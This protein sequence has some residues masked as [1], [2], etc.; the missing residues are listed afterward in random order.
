M[1]GQPLNLTKIDSKVT[2]KHILL[3]EDEPD[4][5]LVTK[6]RLEL[7]GF[8]VSLA[9]DGME[10][11]AM[12]KQLRPDLVLLD[13]KMPQLDGYQVCKQLK[14]YEATKNIPVILFSGSSS[15]LLALERKCLELGADDFIRKPFETKALIKK[16]ISL[17]K[18][19]A[20]ENESS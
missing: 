5:A 6:T 12:V 11:L 20:G 17:T 3:V 2:T 18:T 15:Y 14:N 19:V 1:N 10:A 9:C 13:L 4:V 16:I 8:R 7:E